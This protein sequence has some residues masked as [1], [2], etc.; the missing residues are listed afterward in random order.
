[1]I[2]PLRAYLEW[3]G[4]TERT[5][6]NLSRPKFVLE[7]CRSFAVKPFRDYENLK[8]GFIKTSRKRKIEKIA[9]YSFTLLL[10]RRGSVGFR[11]IRVMLV[12]NIVAEVE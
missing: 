9:K 6:T 12:Y 8:L 7:R 1:M 4:A 3:L 5:A 2:P 11:A 10:L